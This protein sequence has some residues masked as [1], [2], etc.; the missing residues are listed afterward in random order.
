[1]KF[2]F[3]LFGEKLTL[4]LEKTLNFI[5]EL[6]RQKREKR[7]TGENENRFPRE[8]VRSR[9]QLVQG[10]ARLN[11]QNR[12]QSDARERSDEE[13]AKRHVEN[14]RADVDEPV[15]QNRRDA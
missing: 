2:S 7:A 10:F 15:G 4:F 11:E 6:D 3:F 1:M 8:N 9:S 5:F 14:R 13:G 12:R